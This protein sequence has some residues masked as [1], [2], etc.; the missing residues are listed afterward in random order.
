MTSADRTA[1]I[2]S[3]ATPGRI[4]PFPLPLT[5]GAA[6]PVRTETQRTGNPAADATMSLDLDVLAETDLAVISGVDTEV[7]SRLSTG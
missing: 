3:R 6:T 7:R 1:E 4:F 5:G 2:T